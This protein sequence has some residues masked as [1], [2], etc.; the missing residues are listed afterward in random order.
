[1]PTNALAKGLC[2]IAVS[3][4]CRTGAAR[5]V[6]TGGGRGTQ[7]SRT[8][9]QATVDRFRP[10]SKARGG[11]RRNRLFS[12]PTGTGRPGVTVFL[13]GLLYSYYDFFR[14][15]KS[16]FGIFRAE[17]LHRASLGEGV[18]IASWYVVA[19]KHAAVGA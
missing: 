7:G 10:G 11:K 17:R 1:M 14:P 12:R 8:L 5:A 16:I 18:G 4:D 13:Q 15:A 9:I 3:R 19:V 2:A 6:R